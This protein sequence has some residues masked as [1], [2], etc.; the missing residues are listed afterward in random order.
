MFPQGLIKGLRHHGQAHD[1]QGRVRDVSVP[2]EDP[3]AE[4]PHVP[5]DARDAGRRAEVQGVHDVPADAART[6]SSASSATPRTA[7]RPLQ[8]HRRLRP[9]HVLRDVRGGAA[10]STRCTFTQDFERAT[11][12]KGTLTYRAHRRRRRDGRLRD[13]RAGGAPRR[14]HG[15]EE[16]RMSGSPETGA[17]VLFFLLAAAVVGL[18]LMMLFSRNFV[19][20]AAYLAGALLGVRG[21]NALLDATFLA[22]LQVFIYAGAITVVVVF[23]VMMTRVGVEH[24]QPAAAAAVGP[25]RG[26]RRRAVRRRACSTRSL[27]FVPLLGARRAAPST[28]R[29]SRRCS[30]ASTRRRSRSAR[31]SCSPRSSAR[32]TWRRRRST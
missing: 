5:L 17:Y 18:S 10:R 7:R 23:V 25:G 19:H 14:R 11:Y 3:A 28:R 31:S 26:R 21:L 30:S 13:R 2:P 22:L 12:D 20:S 1:R 6:T 8:L 29:R 24:W 27:G 16:A 9:L 32:S 4:E 15:G